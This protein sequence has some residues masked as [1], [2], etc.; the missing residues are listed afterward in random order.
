MFHTPDWRDAHVSRKQAE[1][2]HQRMPIEE[3]FSQW[4]YVIWYAAATV[5]A[6]GVFVWIAV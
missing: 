2:R 1:L 5:L 6:L 4:D 3:E